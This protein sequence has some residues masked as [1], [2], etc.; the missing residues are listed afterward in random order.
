MN[1]LYCVCFGAGVA[2]FAYSRLGRY[3]GYGNRQNVAIL[4]G[5]V[6]VLSTLVFYTIVKF[7][8]PA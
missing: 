8:V 7:F 6:F 2:A 1:F 5:V 4:T 3:I